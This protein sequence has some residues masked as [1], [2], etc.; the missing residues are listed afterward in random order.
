MDDDGIAKY[1]DDGSDFDEDLYLRAYLGQL[2]NEEPVTQQTSTKP[3]ER[4]ELK[5]EQK[6]ANSNPDAL[7]T[8][9]NTKETITDKEIN[10]KHDE[11]LHEQE[12]DEDEKTNSSDFAEEEFKKKFVGSVCSFYS[13]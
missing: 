6:S 3:E 4:H 5:E 8:N 7:E 1:D 13:L 10:E 11:D 12:K 2:G 9:E